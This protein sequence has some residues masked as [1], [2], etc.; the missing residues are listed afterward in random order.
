MALTAQML[1]SVVIRNRV[2]HSV[3]FFKIRMRN[4][5]DQLLY[6]HMHVINN[7]ANW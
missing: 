3:L 7:E 4:K 5:L 2:V 6:V 1:L